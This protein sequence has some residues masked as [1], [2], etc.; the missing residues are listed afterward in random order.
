M[1]D[2]FALVQIKQENFMCLF[3]KFFE[4]INIDNFRIK[5]LVFSSDNLRRKLSKL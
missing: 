5:D 2:C 1:E 4:Q 3:C